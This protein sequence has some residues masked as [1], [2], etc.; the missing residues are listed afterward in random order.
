MKSLPLLAA[1]LLCPLSARGGVAVRLWI[2][3]SPSLAGPWEKLDLLTAPKDPFGNPV[4]PAMGRALYRT[5]I[6]VLPDGAGMSIPLADVPEEHR[7]LAKDMLGDGQTGA[8]AWPAD[9]VLGPDVFPIYDKASNAGATPAF[10]EFKVLRNSPL[11][12]RPGFPRNFDDDCPD[13]DAGSLFISLTDTESP[14]QESSQSGPALTER[15]WKLAGRRDVKVFRFGGE[16]FAAEDMQGHL[17]ANVGTQPFKPD[18]ALALVLT[19]PLIWEGNTETG[20]NIMP[21]VPRSI[22]SFYESYPQFVADYLGNAV[23]EKLRQRRAA[24]ATLER[25]LDRGVLPQIITLKV[26]EEVVILAGQAITERSLE[27]EEE[28]PIVRLSAPVPGGPGLKLSAA[29]PGNGLLHVIHGPAGTM[30]S[31]AIQV[32][33]IDAPAARSPRGGF[34]PGW[35]TSSEILVGSKD[36]Q[37]RYA[38]MKSSSWDGYVGCG[39]N[40]WAML[41]AWF[42]REKGLSAAFGDFFLSEAPFEYHKDSASSVRAKL[43]PVVGSLRSFCGT[44]DDPNSDASPTMPGEMPDGVLDYLNIPLTVQMLNYSW[45]ARW[46]DLFQTLN[47]DGGATEVRTAL[48]QGRCACVG[49]GN[50][51]HYAVAYGYRRQE[52]IATPGGPPLYVRRQ[53]RCNM[54]WGNGSDDWP[55]WQWRDFYDTFFSM[56]LRLSKGPNHP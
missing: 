34:K 14:R 55:N 33:A 3:S 5:Q 9:C 41:L 32:T 27:S 11:P 22:P 21:T 45:K 44:F 30:T 38:Q 48:N 12:L 39:P 19:A 36:N 54:G 49:L 35:Q 37:V 23:Y 28:N 20:Q 53:L 52:Y 18:P 26:G 42:E 31:F 43:K 6:E 47:G 50:Y 8:E 40:A 51:W 4:V 1:L 15:L 13:P 24:R 16:F 7:K 10:L 17:L 2:E 56:N 46:S 29:A 25:N